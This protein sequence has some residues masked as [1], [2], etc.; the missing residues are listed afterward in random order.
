MLIGRNSKGADLLELALSTR[1]GVVAVKPVI[2]AQG[3]PLPVRCTL[4]G[5]TP[6]HFS[7]NPP[8]F[9]RGPAGV[10]GRR[11]AHDLVRA[12]RCGTR[13]IPIDNLLAPK[14]FVGFGLLTMTDGRSR[15]DG[16]RQRYPS[17]VEAPASSMP[18]IE[19]GVMPRKRLHGTLRHLSRG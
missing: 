6:I 3:W 2:T 14:A 11:I 8:T 9:L 17:H 4:R 12:M 5:I 19:Q 18:S 16:K 10:V 13:L 15:Q 1:P 7:L